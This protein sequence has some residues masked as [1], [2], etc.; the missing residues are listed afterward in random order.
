MARHCEIPAKLKVG[1]VEYNNPEDDIQSPGEKP[2][3][4]RSSAQQAG[5]RN[6]KL[7]ML[8]AASLLQRTALKRR[9]GF[10]HADTLLSVREQDNSPRRPCLPGQAVPP[11]GHGKDNNSN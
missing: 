2:Q 7:Q 11:A 3:S 1:R 8:K 6:S 10:P 5:W 4:Q 9:M